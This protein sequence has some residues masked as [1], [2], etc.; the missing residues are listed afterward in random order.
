MTQKKK[1]PIPL[2][3]PTQE[4]TEG[5]PQTVV[6]P[7]QRVPFLLTLWQQK[8]QFEQQRDSFQQSFESQRERIRKEYISK[9][10]QKRDSRVLVYYSHGLLDFDE[11]DMF[12]ELFFGINK[13]PRLDLYLFSNGGIIDAAYKIV[14]L[15]RE[16]CTEDFGVII[17][18]RAKSA[19]TLIALGADEVIMGP[20]SELGPIDPM[21]Q[22]KDLM[23]RDVLIPAQSVKKGIEYIES[24][25]E[26]D[27]ERA[28]LFAPLVEKID[29]AMIGAYDLAMESSVQY[30]EELL[31]E[32]RHPEARKNASEKAMK[33]TT[34]YFSHGFVIDRKVAKDELG[35][36]VLFSEEDEELW[37]YIWNL[38]KI[39]DMQIKDSHG[40]IKTFFETINFALI[41][42]RPPQQQAEMLPS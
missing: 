21:V 32:N 42:E 33:L 31:R 12:N 27:P 7:S 30:V 37:E 5:L 6:A 36:K 19:A 26:Q 24:R 29:L 20:V 8:A 3:L 17:P 9:I 2:E 39:Y 16:H 41:G 22:T 13:V 38:H 15:C 18:Y 40:R 4:K 1:G 35:L 28:I 34:Q 25:I 10:Q 23:G 14:R 11:V